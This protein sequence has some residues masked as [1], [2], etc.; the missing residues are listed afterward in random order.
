MTIYSKFKQLSYSLKI[1]LISV[2]VLLLSLGIMWYIQFTGN[3]VDQYR[4][5]TTVTFVTSTWEDNPSLYVEI[6]DTPYKHEY[7]LMFRWQIERW[8]GMIFVFPD[9]KIRSFWMKNTYIPL[10][11][12]F[13]NATWE[14]VSLYYG[15]RPTDETP[16]SSIYPATYVIEANS[17]WALEAKITTWTKIIIGDTD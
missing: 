7:G 9:E 4:E 1:V 2:V 13:V 3:A 16:I 11:M 17:W 5:R 14:V 10:D 6:A 15:A 8:D 12:I